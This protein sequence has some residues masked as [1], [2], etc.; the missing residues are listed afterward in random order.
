MI[1]IILYIISFILSTICA[2]LHKKQST[3]F[4]DIFDLCAAIFMAILPGAFIVWILMIVLEFLSKQK[5]WN[6]RIW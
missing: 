5:F 2:I 4:V 6:W 3:G 1:L